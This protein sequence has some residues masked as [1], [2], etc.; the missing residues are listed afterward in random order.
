MQLTNPQ[1]KASAILQKTVLHESRSKIETLAPINN[2]TQH[3]YLGEEE[4]QTTT[5]S[6]ES[7]WTA[8]T[9]LQGLRAS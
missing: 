8:C 1:L 5:T 6:T 2:S 4:T 9:A 7:C 3:C